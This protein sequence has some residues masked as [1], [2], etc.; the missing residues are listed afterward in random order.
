[1]NII[2]VF[3]V[4]ETVDDRGR[5]GNLIGV[6]SIALSQIEAITTSY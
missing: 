3:A 4:Y 2:Q 6:R 1:M 5:R